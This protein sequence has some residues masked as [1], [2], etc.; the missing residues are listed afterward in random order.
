[1]NNVESNRIY[2]NL[3]LVL[4]MMD[5][6]YMSVC[7]SDWRFHSILYYLRRRESLQN[8]WI[9]I[10]IAEDGR[11]NGFCLLFYLFSKTFEEDM[12]TFP[13]ITILYYEILWILK[14]FHEWFIQ[15]I[16]ICFPNCYPNRF[17]TSFRCELFRRLFV[18]YTFVI[19]EVCFSIS[20]FWFIFFLSLL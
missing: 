4:L 10:L 8:I 3:T 7:Q 15:L 5:A 18:F 20:E 16:Y 11:E 1:M 6:N 2:L 13:L 14:D 12:F 17:R 19:S 9:D